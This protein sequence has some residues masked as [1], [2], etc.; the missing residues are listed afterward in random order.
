MM[1]WQKQV[2]C[3]KISEKEKKGKKYQKEPTN[4]RPYVKKWNQFCQA[5]IT[6]HTGH[7]TGWCLFSCENNCSRVFEWSLTN[8]FGRAVWFMRCLE[9]LKMSNGNIPEKSRSLCTNSLNIS[10]L[11]QTNQKRL[12]IANKT[13]LH[14]LS[15]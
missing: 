3:C 13:A 2:Q 5:V 1:K 6:Q 7:G 11:N 9:L 8:L 12:Y 14:L 4:H 10:Q 15:V